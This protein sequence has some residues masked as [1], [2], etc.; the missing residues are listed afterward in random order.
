MKKIVI[1]YPSDEKLKELEQRI[2][3]KFKDISLLKLSLV[4]K[5]AGDGKEGFICNERLEW[6][7]DRVLGLLTARYFFNSFKT[8]N[9]GELTRLFNSAVNGNNCAEASLQLGLDHLMIVSK[10]IS[11]AETRNISVLA[12]AF[13]ALLGA[14]YSDG[15]LES[16]EYLVNIAIDISK[17]NIKKSENYKSKL[18]EWLQKRGFDA[19]IYHLVHKEGPDHAPNF[20]I[21][22]DA[23]GKKLQAS[24]SSKQLTEQRCAEL[25]FE[26]FI[27]NGNKNKR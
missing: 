1:T 23:M 15:G 13:E 24:G 9:E 3:Y 5:S 16:C 4:H 22:V 10:S 14:V 2:H 27:N 26:E 12:D 8:I 19:P 6:L 21:E 20:I 17:K 25:F 7:G 11:H 18:Q